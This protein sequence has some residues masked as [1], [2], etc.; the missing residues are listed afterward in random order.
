[1]QNIVV[2]E[3][4]ARPITEYKIEI[5]ERKGLGHP[6]FICDS[7]MD[8]ISVRLSKEYLEKFGAVMHHNIDKGLLVAGEAEQAFGGGEIKTPMKLVIGDRAT[9]EVGDDEIDVNE[10]AI[11][12]SKK[13]IKENLRFVDPEENVIYQV[14]LKRGSAALKDL[15]ERKGAVLGA[16]DTSAAIGYAPMSPTELIVYKTEKFLNSKEFKKRFPESG[17]DIKV[18]G[19]RSN[20]ELHLT[21][22]M[23]LVDRYIESETDYFRKKEA[24]LEEIKA[25]VDKESGMKNYVY[26][27]TLDQKGRGLAGCY[28]TV[29]GT[30]A[31]DA[32]CGQVGRGNRVNGIIPLNRPIGSEAAAGKNP[33]SHVG[34]IYNVLT[35][36]IAKKIYQEISGMRE[37]YVWLLSQIGQP[38]DQPKI[39][40]AQVILEKGRV[41]DIENEIKA[42]VEDELADIKSFTMDLARGR[43]PIC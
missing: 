41:E 8:Q 2:E 5:V 38:I 18:M 24:I 13:W 29:T 35:H 11:S 12:T 9:F 43:I 16:N 23:A 15:F 28:L 26:L 39:V 25:F 17:E 31:E 3:L 40:V 1:M 30:S 32:D 34:K 21:I 4:H 42:V 10:I 27:N 37:V 7:I 20:T 19:L 6:D 33:V 36:Q 14:E 22:A